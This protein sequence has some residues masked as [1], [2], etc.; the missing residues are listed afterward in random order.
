M[1]TIEELKDF[2]KEQDCL[3]KFNYLNNMDD[4]FIPN[5]YGLTISNFIAFIKP[6]S[7]WFQSEKEKDFIFWLFDQEGKDFITLGDFKER[8]LRMSLD[9]HEDILI[10]FYDEM[11]KDKPHS[12]CILRLDFYSFLASNFK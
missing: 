8:F 12:N 7:F 6:H 3:D 11:K 1:I 10:E 2:F 5:H 4:N 9:L